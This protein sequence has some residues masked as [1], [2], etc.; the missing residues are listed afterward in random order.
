MTMVHSVSTRIKTRQ[1]L[2]NPT[3]TTPDPAIPFDCEKSPGVADKVH[4]KRREPWFR[5][6]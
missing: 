2:H 6:A 1:G 5:P 3:V 4:Q